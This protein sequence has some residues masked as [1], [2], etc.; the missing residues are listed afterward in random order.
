MGCYD[1]I[2]NKV[3]DAADIDFPIQVGKSID[4]QDRDYVRICWGTGM[5][6]KRGIDCVPERLR[7]NGLMR[8]GCHFGV[9]RLDL[10]R[11]L[12]SGKIETDLSE[13]EQAA[14]RYFDIPLDITFD[15]FNRQHHGMTLDEYADYA[16]KAG[17]HT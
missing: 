6:V 2:G 13:S 17:K 11:V 7:N 9:S 10:E 3:L 8:H 4:G 1:I 16:N 14:F 5:I 15:E 12:E